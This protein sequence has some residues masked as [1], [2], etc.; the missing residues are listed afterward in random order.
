MAE[1][2]FK[3]KTCGTLLDGL[4]ASATNGVV[5]CPACFNVWTI[6]R[7]EMSPAALSFLRMGEHD[8]DTGKFDDALSAYKKA[9]ELDPK[10]PEAYFG[11]AL[12]SFRIQYL[13]DHIHNR[14]QPI[15]HGA[16]GEPFI[17]D[18][19]YMRALLN[20]TSEQRA[21]YEKKGKEIDYILSEFS[22]LE[23]SGTDYDCFLCV[24]V[25]GENGKT[26][27]SKD[28]DYIYDLLKN[29]GYKPF[30]SERELRNVTGADYEAR[31][32]YA[33]VKS[34][35]MLVICR[36]E[37]YLQTPWVKNEYTR[38]LKLVNDEEKE[39]DS[40]TLVFY[41]KPI[42]RLPG[43]NGKLQGIDFSHRDAD[44][45]IADFV[46]SHTPAAKAKRE[47]AERDKNAQAEEIRR[48]IEEQKRAQEAQR[49]AQRELEEKLQRLSESRA[50]GSAG[51]FDTTPLLK[52]AFTFLADG[53]FEN[54][55][56][57]AEKVLD[58][59]PE[60]AE[61]YLVKFCCELEVTQRENLATRSEIGEFDGPNYNKLMQYAGDAL[62]E[63]ID[64]Y[65]QSVKENEEKR[66]AQE[67]LADFG[68]TCKRMKEV[69]SVTSLNQILETFESL[70]DIEG[71][72]KKI[73]ACRQALSLAQQRDAL[74]E[75]LSQAQKRKGSLSTTLTTEGRV[76][77]SRRSVCMIAIIFGIIFVAI[78]GLVLFFLPSLNWP[79]S[80][81][82]SHIVVGALLAG[83]GFVLGKKYKKRQETVQSS[84]AWEETRIKSLEQ[85]FEEVDKKFRAA[86]ES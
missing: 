6:P 30:Y 78:G 10:E 83:I 25:S 38:F 31:I 1:A 34:E 20:A 14:M 23:K 58:L 13:K 44:G 17:E 68:Q 86:L 19:N 27:D 73:E 18:K 67:R 37:E 29:K 85:Q 41:E 15:C 51:G 22:R 7:K 72:E 75:E 39:S 77:K 2:S 11:M 62:K 40:I 56:A 70:K 52:R 60:S 81:C 61:A 46:E 65:L 26:E 55:D 69:D 59:V 53:D 24:K 64:G 71:A 79:I 32:L 48:Q 49:K 54:A 16:K 82:I 45:K 35:C 42:E 9:A 66:V 33:L 36:D 8:L 80:T 74:K 12:A 76:W 47:A 21:E 63:E 5:E 4:V 3:C 84:F 43:K 28:A 57:Y 50:S